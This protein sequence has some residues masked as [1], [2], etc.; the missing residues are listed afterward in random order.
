M[1]VREGVCGDHPH[2]MQPQPLCAEQPV[3]MLTILLSVGGT[4]LGTLA[5]AMCVYRERRNHG[6]TRVRLEELEI[7]AALEVRDSWRDM[8][9]LKKSCL[10]RTRVLTW[11][12]DGG[13]AHR[14]KG[15]QSGP[16]S[17]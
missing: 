10:C 17:T 3:P 1:Q 5:L 9:R 8:A 2:R 12:V 11:T 4:L 15:L 7:D 13:F 14:C 16:C 6:R